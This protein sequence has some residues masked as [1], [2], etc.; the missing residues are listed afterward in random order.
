MNIQL[1]SVLDSILVIVD[2]QNDF[3]S[4][5]G[6]LYVEGTENERK[7]YGNNVKLVKDIKIFTEE[8]QSKT[9]SNPYNYIT[10]EDIHLHNS[11][12][13]SKFPE[14]CIAGSIGQIYD[15]RLTDLYNNACENIEKG[16]NPNIFSYS[17]STSEQFEDHI[18]KLKTFRIKY[19]YVVGL[20]FNYCVGESAI[21]YA[22]QG[23]NTYIIRSLTRS[24]PDY[25][26]I[27]KMIN[28]LDLYGVELI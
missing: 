6:S 26:S 19:V 28:K 12:E 14:H 3:V 15:D 22:C 5:K 16:L 17:I 23:F 10:T 20:A 8:F 7:L 11:I 1:N 13:F 2:M 24:V 18:T 27:E 25:N 4:P 9:S 21:S